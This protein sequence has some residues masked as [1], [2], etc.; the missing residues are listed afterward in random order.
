MARVGTTGAGQLRHRVTL[1]RKQPTG[2]GQGGQVLD[3]VPFATVWASVR[4][5]SGK[6]RLQA[7]QVQSTVTHRVKIRW[8]ASPDNAEMPFVFAGDRLVYKGVP[9][10]IRA[11]IDLDER[12]RFLLLDA[13]SG[14]AA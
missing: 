5:L 4:P 9:Y 13:E 1:Q 2:D 12:R 8:R 6:D 11:V 3:W 7:A 10:N 14:V